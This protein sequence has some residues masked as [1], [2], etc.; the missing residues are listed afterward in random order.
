[1]YNVFIMASPERRPRSRVADRRDYIANQGFR[2][3]SVVVHKKSDLTFKI[4]G[5]RTD[6][7][8]DVTLSSLNGKER[9]YKTRCMNPLDFKPLVPVPPVI[10]Y[11]I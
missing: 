6:W 10:D 11:Q 1:M 7:W 4:K 9:N 2:N 5:I 8:I 3:D